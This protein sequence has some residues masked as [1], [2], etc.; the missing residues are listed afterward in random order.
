M[1]N[2]RELRPI[3]L[4]KYRWKSRLFLI[5]APSH[6]DGD[7][8]RQS[9]EFDGAAHELQDRDIVVIEL[10]ETG[11]ST[12]GALPM[13]NEEQSVLRRRFE[14][15]ADGF[16][17]ILIGKDGAVKLRSKQPVGSGDLFELIDSMP[18]RKEEMR[19]KAGGPVDRD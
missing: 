8:L 18:M 10:L 2:D 16:C 14:V 5:F 7:Y 19:G 4:D 9:S 1:P 17:F 6:E 11:R 13:A 15:P 3:D 12:M